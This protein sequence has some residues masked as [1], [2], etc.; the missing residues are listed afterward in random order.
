MPA[1]H[2]IWQDK[3]VQA[4]TLLCAVEQAWQKAAASAGLAEPPALYSRPSLVAMAGCDSTLQQHAHS[5]A[6]I[7]AG[8]F[9]VE[10]H[11][12]HPQPSASPKPWAF[13]ARLSDT[14]TAATG[15]DGC[16]A[17]HLNQPRTAAPRVLPV[18]RRRTP[19]WRA[20]DDTGSDLEIRHVSFS[21]S[22]SHVA[23]VCFL[24]Q[25]PS[26][27]SEG[28]GDP[29][30]EEE[31]EPDDLQLR[32]VN[33]ATGR[34]F[35]VTSMSQWM[36]VDWA[37]DG[38]TLVAQGGSELLTVTTSGTRLR[39]D[40]SALDSTAAQIAWR[41]DSSG[42]YA[43]LTCGY[44]YDIHAQGGRHRAVDMHDWLCQAATFLPCHQHGR[45]WVV[46]ALIRAREGL[47]VLALQ[48]AG[49]LEASPQPEDFP[50]LDEEL[51]PDSR[52]PTG[53]ACRS[54]AVS[55]QHVAVC[56]E[57]QPGWPGHGAVHLFS[58]TSQDSYLWLSVS[59]RIPVHTP[60]PALALS[61]CG[62]W[63][64]VVNAEGDTGER[65]RTVTGEQRPRSG[66]LHIEHL[67]SHRNLM[68]SALSV[69]TALPESLIQ[70][71]PA[72]QWASDSSAL[73]VSA[74][75]NDWSGPCRYRVY[76][77]S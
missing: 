21:P 44:L 50:E 56:C 36:R 45:L 39:R 54:L 9:Q 60:Q 10:D 63:V 77:L 14:V 16:A 52:M 27:D 2:R 55:A 35:F 51:L 57:P 41:P 76:T 70:H 62:V 47:G 74:S 6:S 15:M 37:P 19:S 71:H 5:C 64:A 67:D 26:D 73:A 17:I 25:P 59:N 53:G 72:L 3:R 34:A 12:Q 8:R 7:L 38:R 22:G 18:P 32:L 42:F 61:P 24:E 40:I 46:F 68:R 29:E 43:C 28:S 23:L 48:P 4:D 11:D 33:L 31:E 65:K 20:D 58:I 1:V 75:D 49:D 13:S 30:Y 66:L 69:S